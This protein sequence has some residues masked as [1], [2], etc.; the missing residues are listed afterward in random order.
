MTNTQTEI[1]YVNRL[2]IERNKKKKQKPIVWI[3]GKTLERRKKNP[4]TAQFNGNGLY[5]HEIRAQVRQIA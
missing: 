2:R 5:P 4:K 3:V 1:I